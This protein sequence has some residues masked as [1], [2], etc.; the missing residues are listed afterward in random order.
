MLVEAEAGTESKSDA[1]GAIR[2]SF[3]NV[4]DVQELDVIPAPVAGGGGPTD[5]IQREQEG[6]EAA[7][8]PRWSDQLRGEEGMIRGIDRT[9]R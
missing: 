1:N 6:P 3:A 8:S 7:A 2:D 5:Q 4:S 9:R